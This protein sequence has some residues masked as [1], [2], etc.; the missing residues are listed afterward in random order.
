MDSSQFREAAKG[1]I[2]DI[3]NYY[4]TLESRNVLPSVSPGYLR[5]LLPTSTPSEG[6]SWETIK[7]DIGRV[8]IPGLTHWQ[9][10][11]FMA[12]FP[13]NSSFEAMLGEMY[14]GAFNAAAFNWICSPA[15]T[16]LET[17]VM[18][19]VAKLIALPKEFLSDGEGGGIIQGTA[20]EVV[21]TALVAARE[22]IIR[23]KLG[24]MPEGEERMDKAA[25]IRSKLVA[26]GSEHAHS[27]TQKAAM[28]AGVRYRNVA[29]PESTNYS[30]TASALRQTIL[31]CREK[32]LEPFYFTITIGSTGT[33]AIDD[34]EGIAA[35]TQE[36]PD[37]WIHVDAAY[38]G[39]ALVCPEY[40]H[41][42]KPISSFDSF[43]FNLHKWL[44]VNFDC[45]AFFVKKRRDLMDTYSITP[46]YLRNPHSEQ[47]L[48]T[49]YRDWQIPL[50]RRFRSL[51]VWFVLRSYGVSGL[52]AFIRKHIQLGEYFA[53]LLESKKDMFSITTKPSFGLVSFQILPQAPRDAKADQP[54]PRHEAY[55]NDFQPNAEAQYR[56]A[57]NA[58][59]KSVYEEVNKKG[60]FFLTS[61][62]LEG[63][64]VIRVVSATVKSEEKWMK[65]LF[66][67]LVKIA[68]EEEN[69]A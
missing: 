35:L 38:A 9:S 60:E 37:I 4:D 36:F 26:L 29:A 24:D 12:F 46:S 54:D 56:E 28:I 55:T 64:Y 57:V 69:K 52:Q 58:T 44:L 67:V 20:S 40:Q 10:P 7:A 41:L 1:A 34:L 63:K 59:T 51:K 16:E 39:S 49:D 66:D 2:D 27:S 45:S 23:R 22:R 21:L 43:N 5:P 18:D 25:D 14:S 30:V 61:T 53:S 11:K 68:E 48:V 15:V 65:A 19:W 42:C 33:C 62:V 3:A 8:I 50:G 13:C 47:G 32:G 6:E 17:I 31:S